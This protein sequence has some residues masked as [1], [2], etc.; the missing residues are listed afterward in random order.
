VQRDG[1]HLKQEISVPAKGEYFFR[2]GIH[3]LNSDHVGAVELPVS[4]VSKLPSFA[5]EGAVA[6]PESAPN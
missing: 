3:D 5:T 6:T 2:I 1:I 4:A